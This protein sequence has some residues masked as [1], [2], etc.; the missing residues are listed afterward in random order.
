MI[1]EK[2]T[3]RKKLFFVG[4]LLLFTAI[5]SVYLMTLMGKVSSIQKFER[6]HIEVSRLLDWKL[7]NYF[8]LIENP[9]TENLAKADTILLA[10]SDVH[11][12]MGIIALQA[13]GI[14]QPIDANNLPNAFEK[15]LFRMFGYGRLFD[16]IDKDMVA[17][18]VI[19]SKF[20]LLKTKK[21][22][23]KGKQELFEAIHHI[24][25]YSTEFAPLI[26]SSATL[27]GNLMMAISTILL[28]FTLILVFYT[29]K[30]ILKTLSQLTEA[31]LDLSQGSG[32]LTQRL[33][34]NTEDEIG[35]AGK[36][37]DNFIELVQNTLIKIKLSSEEINNSGK[38][39][40]KMADIIS[41]GAAEQASATEE[42][43][44]SMEEMSA[45]I[46]QTTENSIQTEKIAKQA[47][48]NIM[49]VNKAFTKTN[50]AMNEIA[51]KILVIN[52][53]A[54]KTDFL[55][56]NASI[57]AARAGEYGKGFAIVA[58]EV[59]KLAERS[60]RAAKEIEKISVDSLHQVEIS[61]RLLTDVIPFIQKTSSLVQEIASS[62][63]EL[64]SGVDQIN[65]SL[66]QLSKVT[67]QNSATS[68]EMA[69][70]AKEFLNQGA[71]L[72][73]NISFFTL[74]D[75]GI[76]DKISEITQQ[77]EKLLHAVKLLKQKKKGVVEESV[78]KTATPPSTK[79]EHP[80][81]HQLEMGDKQDHEYE[82]F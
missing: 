42:I 26:R 17:Y 7:D 54:A 80:K 72:A 76:D 53:I 59:R 5:I 41:Q 33:N 45:N 37:I 4:G 58:S 75:S 77:T 32:D 29:A 55:A 50:Q 3:I 61:G 57:E 25:E 82:S 68:E 16:L 15:M 48:T 1:I 28:L 34:I 22:D 13:K 51:Q 14:A 40:R 67:Q 38:E 19:E 27:V 6:D 36:N 9:T 73:D 21:I 8:A 39:L 63:V 69:S 52:D 23:N 81:G 12:E 71:L 79:T 10:K 65:N 11:Q 18:K 64:N 49:I 47:E 43:S 20:D 70:G 2:Y 66:Q 30:S 62:G 78:P 46:N 24:I 31:T 60:Q 35:L 74:D 44:A 56:V